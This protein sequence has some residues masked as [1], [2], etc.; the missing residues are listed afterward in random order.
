M[1]CGPLSMLSQLFSRTLT[2]KYHI[3]NP[4][5]T[6]YKIQKQHSSDDAPIRFF[7]ATDSITPCILL[8]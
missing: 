8:P 4:Y 3:I 1:V 2:W 6:Q 5:N 7:L